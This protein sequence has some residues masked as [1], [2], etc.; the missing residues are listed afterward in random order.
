MDLSKIVERFQEKFD[1]IAVR[2]KERGTTLIGPHRDD[3]EFF[4]NSRDVQNFGSQGQQITTFIFP[5][6]WLRRFCSK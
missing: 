4:V 5:I 6:Y 1:K 2:E 3:L